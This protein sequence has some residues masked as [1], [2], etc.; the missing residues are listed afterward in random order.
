MTMSDREIAIR[1]KLYRTFGGACYA[2]KNAFYELREDAK[3]LADLLRKER[4]ER[5]EDVP[6]GKHEEDGGRT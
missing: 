6:D 2:G 4:K 1:A 5:G 3:Y